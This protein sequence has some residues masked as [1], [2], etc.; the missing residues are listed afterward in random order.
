ML[1][2]REFVAS[3]ADP[4]TVRWT[5]AARTLL[6]VLRLACRLLPPLGRLLARTTAGLLGSVFRK[7]DAGDHLAAYEAALLGL[8]RQEVRE[9]RWSSLLPDWRE[10]YWWQ[11]LALAAGEA[12]HL[13]IHER[14]HVSSLF[15]RVPSPG[16]MYAAWCLQRFAD[17]RWKDGDTD[18]AL[19]L[20][21]RAVLADSSWGHAHVYLGWLGLASGRFDPL[22]H[23]RDALRVE[24][25]SAE[26]IRATQAFAETPDLLRSLHLAP[27][28][29]G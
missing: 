2:H 14:A 13:G 15:D 8:E 23:L 11:F 17:W 24:P 19:T 3:Q 16:G 12:E 25:S 7:R 21:Q 1:L 26:T 6:P 20:A 27:G 9:G 18:G 28:V 10:W 29:R 4:A 5:Q 22:P